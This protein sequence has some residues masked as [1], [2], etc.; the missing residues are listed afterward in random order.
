MTIELYFDGSMKD[1]YIGYG[2]LIKADGREIEYSGIIDGTNYNYNSSVAEYVALINGL[3]RINLLFPS[4][5]AIEIFGDSKSLIDTYHLHKSPK[6]KKTAPYHELLLVLLAKF[7]SVKMTWIP[8]GQNKR[9]D[10]I[11]KVWT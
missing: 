8:E 3:T 1:G 7:D 10:R 5:T 4:A 11:S 2:G 6:S 9:V